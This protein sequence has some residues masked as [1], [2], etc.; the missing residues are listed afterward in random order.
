[1]KA[2]KLSRR[3]FLVASAASVAVIAGGAVGVAKLT[4]P[5]AGD[6][7]ATYYTSHQKDILVTFDETLTCMRPFLAAKVGAEVADAVAKETRLEYAAAL[8]PDRQII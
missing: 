3:Q 5:N 7:P 8:I 6:T 2:R 4:Q 1:M